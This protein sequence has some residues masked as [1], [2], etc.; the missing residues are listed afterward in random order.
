MAADLDW[1]LAG[2]A[3][4]DL[5]YTE[6]A[7]FVAAGLPDMNIAAGVAY[8]DRADMAL[9]ADERSGTEELVAVVTPAGSASVLAAAAAVD[10]ETAVAVLEDLDTETAVA[11]PSVAAAAAAACQAAQKPRALTWA[12]PRAREARPHP[13]CH[14]G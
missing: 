10:T 6:F 4:A 13:A 3:S 11:V 14:T 2:V 7:A 9:A 5:D 1:Q 8:N 12:Q